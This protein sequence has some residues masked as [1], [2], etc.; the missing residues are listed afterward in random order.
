MR[1]IIT[2]KRPNRLKTCDETENK[3]LN[4]P[5]VRAQQNPKLSYCGPS[6]RQ[7]QGT[8]PPIARPLLHYNHYVNPSVRPSVS[9]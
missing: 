3:A 9:S 2:G 1:C 7:T 6:L 8:D 4:T 5:A